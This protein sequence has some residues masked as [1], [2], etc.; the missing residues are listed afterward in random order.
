MWIVVCKQWCSYVPWRSERVIAIVT[1]NKKKIIEFCLIGLNNSNLLGQ[2]TN[3]LRVKYTFASPWTLRY[4]GHTTRHQLRFCCYKTLENLCNF[5][6][7]FYHISLVS[8]Y[9]LKRHDI[10]LTNVCHIP[11][12]RNVNF[13]KQS[14]FTTFPINCYMR[15]GN[16]IF[17]FTVIIC[18]DGQF[19]SAC[20][21]TVQIGRQLAETCPDLHIQCTLVWR[22]RLA[23]SSKTITNLYQA[24]RCQNPKHHNIS[25]PL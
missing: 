3:F 17:H 7:I 1:P 10:T 18:T 6:I 25:R 16:I 14:N 20:F 8:L 24:T 4:A 23:S 13:H 15:A 12:Q 21:D 5:I 2:K 19:T 22:V 9:S 11:V